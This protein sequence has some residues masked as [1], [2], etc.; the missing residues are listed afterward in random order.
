MKDQKPL[1][2]VIP[3]LFPGSEN[4]L[5]RPGYMTEIQA[6]GGLPVLL[7]PTEDE[8]DI[9]RL[10]SQVDGLLVPGGQDVE[11][12]YYGEETLPA[13][14]DVQ[15]WRDRMEFKSLKIA[16]ELDLP[17]LCI[18]RGHQVL[19][20]FLGGSLYQD[21]PSQMDFSIIHSM[22]PPTGRIW[23]EVTV[24]RGTPL[25]DL[26]KQEKVGVNSCHHQGIKRLGDGLAVMA[27]A[28]DGIIEAVYMPD[29]RF[30]W[31]IQWHPEVFYGSDPNHRVLFE[32]FVEACRK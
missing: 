26:W 30:V 21:I 9:R 19:N 5:T 27:T 16:L 22:T 7:P 13:C 15:P 2:A 28:P 12:F 32:A 6:A 4:I 25:Y 11:P 29:K 14:G 23:H 8:D 18:C 17:I 3:Q 31:G 20:V 24:A 10:L 1:I